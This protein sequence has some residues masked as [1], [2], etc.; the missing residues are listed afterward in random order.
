MALRPAPRTE[1]ARQALQSL[2]AAAALVQRNR[3]LTDAEMEDILGSLSTTYA[4]RARAAAP[5]ER[6]QAHA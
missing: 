4:R 2:R 5:S 1:A 3:G 6:K